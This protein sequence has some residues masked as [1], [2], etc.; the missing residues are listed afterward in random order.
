MTLQADLRINC[1]RLANMTL[2]M[3]S[4]FKPTSLLSLEPDYSRLLLHRLLLSTYFTIA[5]PL[6]P[7][8]HVVFFLQSFGLKFFL[9]FSFLSL[10][11]SA[12][13]II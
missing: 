2:C 1:C 6:F 4:S 7:V 3:N 8:F 5:F 12:P 11:F 9:A 13:L 10:V